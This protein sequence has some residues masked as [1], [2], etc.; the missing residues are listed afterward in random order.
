MTD[1]PLP[2]RPTPTPFCAL[3][4]VVIRILAIKFGLDAF[5][6]LFPA[7]ATRTHPAPLNV[8]IVFGVLAVATY[9]LWQ[10]SPFFARH[11]TRGQD[12]SLAAPD[13]ALLDLYSFAAVLV[14]LYFAVDSFGP[15]ITWLYYAMRQSS[16]EA[17]LSSQQQAN[18]YTLFK[19]LAKLLLGLALTLNGRKFAAKLI[20]RHNETASSERPA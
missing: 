18:F 14:G 6:F 8:F 2:Q 5:G 7:I 1:S 16:S 15:S 11:I 13:F 3:V 4:T 9:W 17:A 10:L 19:Y 20:K 12:I